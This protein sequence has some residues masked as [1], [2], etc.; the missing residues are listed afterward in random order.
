MG[1]DTYLLGIDLGTMGVK[2]V[3]FRVDG[4]LMGSFYQGYPLDSPFPGWAQQDTGL[5]WTET[6]TTIKESL[7]QAKIDPDSIVGIGCCGQ[8]H[9]PSPLDKSGKFIGPCITWVDQRSTKQVNWVLEHVTQEKVLKINQSFVDNAYTAV[10][11]IWLKENQPKLYKEAWKFLLPKDVLVYFLTGEVSTDK[12]DAYATNMF[13]VWKLDWSDELLDDYGISRDKL[14]PV[15]K[16]QEIIGEVTSKAASETGLKAG[17]PVAAGGGDWACT[18]YGAGF[19]KPGRGVD[20][21]GTVGGFNIAVDRNTAERKGVHIVPEICPGG[22][23][24]SQAAAS[25][26]RWFRNEFCESEVATAERLGTSVY[27]LMDQEAEKIPPGSEGVLV[28]P[29]FIGQRKPRNVNS[30]GLIF[31]LTLTTKRAQIIRAI[32][33]GLAYEMR[34]G[35]EAARERGVKC[36]EIRAIGGASKSRIWRQIKANILQVPYCRINIDEGGCLGA[37]ILAG[38]GTGFFKDLISPVESIVEVV[39]RQTPQEEYLE[40]YT[41]LYEIYFKLDNTLDSQKIYDEYIA[42]LNRIGV[43]ES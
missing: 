39:E 7:S 5:W 2:S 24:G 12:T 36:D 15:H 17:T 26:Y 10:K 32:M 4:K 1:S 35:M 14:A 37:G 11:L 20:M 43:I 16:P 23:G 13:D 31:G 29:H 18:Y 40:R 33:E 30:R 19:V 27:Q 6:C 38:V 8:S 41:E 3:I 28:T 25:I 21:T 9:G 34:K 22:G 42:T